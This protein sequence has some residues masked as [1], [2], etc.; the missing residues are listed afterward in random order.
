MTLENRQ[1]VLIMTDTQRH[2]MLGCYRQTGLQTPFL[3]KLAAG[4]RRFEKA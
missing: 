3:D 1:I 2:D 4:G